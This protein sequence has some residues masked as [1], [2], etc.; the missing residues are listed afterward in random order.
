[1]LLLTYIVLLCNTE[2]PIIAYC[3]FL[4]VDINLRGVHTSH[5]GTEPVAES[6]PALTKAR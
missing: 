6:K 3:H 5:I 1:L 2:S 4:G